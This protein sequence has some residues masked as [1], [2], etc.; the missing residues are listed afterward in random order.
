MADPMITENL[1]DI[2]AG[3]PNRGQLHVFLGDPQSDMCDK[4]VVEPGGNFSPGLWTCGISV[5][6]ETS[7]HFYSPDTLMPDAIASQF[8]PEGLPPTIMSTWN[9]ADRTVTTEIATLSG[10]GSEGCD[11]LRVGLSSGTAPAIVHVVVRGEGPAGGPL[12]NLTQDRWTGAVSTDG[13]TRLTPGTELAGF[14]VRYTPDGDA[15]AILTLTEVN[16]GQSWTGGMRVEHAFQTHPGGDLLPLKR[17]YA[18]VTVDKGFLEARERWDSATPA[19]VY[20]PNPS[21]ERSWTAHASHL[22]ANAETGIPRI[23]VVDYPVLWVRDSTIQIRAL[24]NLGRHDLARSACDHLAPLIFSGGFGAEADAPGQGI[25]ALVTHA[26]STGD[27]SW[28]A[29]VYPDIQ[30][31]VQW[32]DRM[33]TTT[34]PLYAP[35]SNRMPKYL[36]SPAINLVCLPAENGLIQGRMDWQYPLFYINAWAVAGYRYAARAAALLD[37]QRAA[38][39]LNATASELDE[40]LTR[41]L[42]STYSNE[43]DTIVTPYPTEAGVPASGEL[44]GRFESWFKTN[45]ID[46]S[47][48]RIPEPLWSY[49]EAAQAHNALL[50]GLNDVAWTIIEPLLTGPGPWHL[51]VF[52]EGQPEGNESAPFGGLER[53]RG[54]LSA[55]TAGNGNMPHGW[56]SA[57]M[58]NLIRAIFV[59]E[60]LDRLVL[61]PGVPASWWAPR[62]TFGVRD[63]P[64][65]FGP[66]TFR[67]VARPGRTWRYEVHSGQP[68][69]GAPTAPQ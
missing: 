36:A 50:M 42:L 59:R 37:N 9:A 60:D 58:I 25:W 1:F 65:K 16:A 38:S 20:A 49:F 52:G 13:G 29:S 11:F 12:R 62:A 21:V 64:T 23:G 46:K 39:T 31:R 32:L 43:R 48:N 19:K 61:G 27:R 14:Q 7:D 34:T 33:R 68:W 26:E 2:V 54:W 15:I 41:T 56:T 47:G 4:T 67:A 30:R 8:G 55:G 28:L 53:S 18:D 57:E 35:S 66:L 5:W 3:T 10:E 51:H 45:R 69:I 22:L 6:I 40:R 17:P 44:R 63:F 24:D